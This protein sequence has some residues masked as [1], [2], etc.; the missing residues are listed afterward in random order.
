[1]SQR[2]HML[3]TAAAQGVALAQVAKAGDASAIMWKLG[4]SFDKMLRIRD[5]KG[6]SSP[7]RTSPRSSAF[8][9]DNFQQSNVG[10]AF[11][12]VCSKSNICT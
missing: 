10:L 12:C 8:D 4:H 11:I 3:A 2:S 1:M 6:M 9:S 5:I 7:L